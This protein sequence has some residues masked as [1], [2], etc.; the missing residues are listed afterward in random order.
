M[1][2]QPRLPVALE[3]VNDNGNDQRA[4][5]TEVEAALHTSEKMGEVVRELSIQN[6]RT[7]R[8]ETRQ[9]KFEDEIRSRLSKLEEWFSGITH[10]VGVR[11]SYS[12]NFRLS[13]PPPRP[14][15]DSVSLEANISPTVTGKFEFSKDELREL[16]AKEI[17][18]DR[19]KVSLQT[20][21]APLMFLR[22]VALPAVVTTALLAI[23]KIIWSTVTVWIHK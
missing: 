13:L 9:I 22:K 21:A 23:A 10:A 8:V 1:S 3:V 2:S 17:E 20:H 15:L 5:S 19:E 7:S 14:K 6:S 11:K 4:E 18:D 16:I 12:G